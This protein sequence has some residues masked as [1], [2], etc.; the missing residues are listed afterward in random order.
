VGSPAEP[1]VARVVE[2]AEAIGVEPV[3]LA[4]E[5]AADWEI[6]VEVA[7]GIRA[8]TLVGGREVD[9]AEATG[10]YLRLT[11][12]SAPGPPPDRVR[13][14]RHAAALRLVSG[15]ADVAPCRVAN[16][17]TA[18]LTNV[19]KP[20]QAALAR[21]CG[22][23]V[24]DTL[25]TNDPEAVRQFLDHHARVVYKSRSGGRSIVRELT[26]TRLVG[27]ERVRS[28][29]TQFQQMV[30]GTNVR[31]HVIG[32]DVHVVEIEARTIDYR[33][34]GCGR[35]PS[36]RPTVLPDAVREACVRL[37]RELELP[38]AGIDLMRDL[39]GGWWCFEVNPSPAYTCYEEP[40]GLPMARSLA[41]WLAGLDAA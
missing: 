16:R 1:P 41:S 14:E 18:M 39:H 2:E 9:L 6:E 32:R 7:D 33:Y 11:S 37:S 23:S 20:Y 19:S 5:D 30:E 25:V 10:L 31:V 13:R 35:A 28:L 24:P 21:E 34:A 4:E 26:R 3:V 38:L 27:L 8:S 22:L 15:W 17:P 36:M 40:T 29:P 12:P